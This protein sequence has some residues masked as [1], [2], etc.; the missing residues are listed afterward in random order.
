MP[1]DCKRH[2]NNFSKIVLPNNI[3]L[4]IFYKDVKGCPGD[5]KGL[6]RTPAN[7][8]NIPQY[9]QYDI[10]VLKYMQE[11]FKAR[12]QMPKIL[13]KARRG[14]IAKVLLRAPGMV[15]KDCKRHRKNHKNNL[16]SN[17]FLLFDFPPAR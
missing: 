12:L 4:N 3:L 5:A 14:Q 10:K 1:K 7:Y 6:Q 13:L 17:I 15:P 9:P 2:H 8:Q 16:L 11:K